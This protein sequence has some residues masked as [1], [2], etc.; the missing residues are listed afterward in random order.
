MFHFIKI[1]QVNSNK[2]SHIIQ[3][4]LVKHKLARKTIKVSGFTDA[5]ANLFPCDFLNVNILIFYVTINSL[6]S[7]NRLLLHP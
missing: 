7:Q 6:S 2:R 1:G 4:F 5:P 3:Q